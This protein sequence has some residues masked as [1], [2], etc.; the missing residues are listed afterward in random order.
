MLNLTPQIVEQLIEKWEGKGFKLNELSDQLQRKNMAILL[1]NEHSYVTGGL[2]EASN[3]T[4]TGDIADFKKILMPLT[5]RIFP[6]LLANEIVGVQPMA[7][8]ASLA[9]AMRFKAS[10]T[11]ASTAQTELGYNTI[12][13]NYTGG[14]SHP[15]YVTGQGASTASS[16]TSAENWSSVDPDA[17]NNGSSMSSNIP[18]AKLSIEQVTVTAQTR[19]LKAR[20][21]LEAAQDLKNVHGLDVEAEMTNLLQYEV[22]A[23]LDR[24]LVD[25]INTKGAAVWHDGSAKASS[26]VVA[27]GDGQWEAEKFRNLYTRMVREAGQIA[28]H[29]RRGAGNFMICS[30]NVVTALDSLGTFLMQPLA[31]AN[32]MEIN[33]GVAKV[34]S[35][36]NRFAVYRD[37]FATTDYV[38]IGYKGP[39]AHNSGI[40][41]CP[42]VPLMISRAV[43]PGAFWP[44][45]GVMTRYGIVDHLF[46]A[47]DF[48]SKFT[49]DFTGLKQW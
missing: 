36:E 27:S 35:I 40:I 29:T 32:P 15:E 21:S 12:D 43:E 45:I 16:V 39:G 6:N 2:Q 5:R 22:A 4:Q 11:Y 37:T 48:Y 23:E 13:Q 3:P 49:V 8:P 28:I 20:Y 46:G 7:G 19:K 18:E 33:P 24:E 10:G 47:Q 9:Y 38:T 41:Y 1:E 34:G 42:Y 26:Y 44:V 17:G 31:G 30:S 25:R 14:T